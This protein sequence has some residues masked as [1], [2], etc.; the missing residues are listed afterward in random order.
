MQDACFLFVAAPEETCL[1]TD[2]QNIQIIV[3]DME[4]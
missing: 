2:L 3:M 4:I 1:P